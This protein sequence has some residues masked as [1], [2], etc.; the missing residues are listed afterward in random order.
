M[1]LKIL[2]PVGDQDKTKIYKATN[3]YW[4]AAT[5]T[6]S[7]TVA[8]GETAVTVSADW[9]VS[10]DYSSILNGRNAVANI[11]KKCRWYY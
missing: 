4:D 9:F 10:L 5:K 7:N 2:K 1:L 3:F 8:E 6:S 11:E